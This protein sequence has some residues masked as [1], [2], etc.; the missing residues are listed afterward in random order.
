MTF[1]VIGLVSLGADLVAEWSGSDA[2][3]VTA[4]G[5]G[6]PPLV[7]TRQLLKAA[8]FLSA[9]GVLGFAVEV[10]MDADTRH[11]L[12]GDVVGLAVGETAAVARTE[13]PGRRR[14]PKPAG[15]CCACQVST[16]TASTSTR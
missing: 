12:I 1:V 3:V 6:A 2:D 5:V 7:V 8:A 4:P 15:P 16:A 9:V 11:I 14:E 10:I 13:R